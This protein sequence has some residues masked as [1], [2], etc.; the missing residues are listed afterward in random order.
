VAMTTAT[1]LG[2]LES[3]TVRPA[4]CPRI[5]NAACQ[6]LDVSLSRPSAR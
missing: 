6:T 1:I 5:L 4:S 3:F 2:V